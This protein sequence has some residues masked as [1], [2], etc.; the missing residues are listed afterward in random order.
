MNETYHPKDQIL[1]EREE[2]Y[3]LQKCRVNWLNL[4]DAN[5]KSFHLA[6]I[7]RGRKNK[8]DCIQDEN[9]VW[10]GEHDIRRTSNGYF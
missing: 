5:I 4:G 10:P 3:W 2:K 6:T 8:V 1:W 7:Q 9:G